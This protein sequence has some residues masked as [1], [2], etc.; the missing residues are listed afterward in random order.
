MYVGVC[1]R[2]AMV[3][4]TGIQN[5]GCPWHFDIWQLHDDDKSEQWTTEVIYPINKERNF[6]AKICDLS[7]VASLN[8]E[9]TLKYDRKRCQSGKANR[10]KKHM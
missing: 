10:N 3:C 1:K 8:Y 5:F 7:C 2:H 6:T 9:D 4:E